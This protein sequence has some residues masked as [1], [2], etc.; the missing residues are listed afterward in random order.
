MLTRIDHGTWAELRLNRPEVRNALNGELIG[1]LLTALHELHADPPRLLLL[2]GAGEVFCAGADLEYMRACAELSRAQ[3]LDDALTLAAMLDALD[4]CP[5]P[6]VAAVRGG[7]YGGG[8]GLLACCDVVVAEDTARF[9]FSEV[10]LGLSPATIAPYVLARAGLAAT[11]ELFLT[12]ARFEV[13]RAQ[14]LGLVHRAVP[15]GELDGAV[16][17]AVGELLKGGPAAQAETKRL[18]R[19]LHWRGA[20]V[21]QRTAELIAEL[22]TSA[23]GQEGLRAF[24]DKRQPS[25]LP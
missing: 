12:A 19:E 1:A 14:Q 11:R 7:A 25:W 9:A 13:P 17:H 2:S 16:E 20:E 15:S 21:R 24:L 18:L 10:R 4:R 22:R 23:E 3:N 6:V 5:C 8:L